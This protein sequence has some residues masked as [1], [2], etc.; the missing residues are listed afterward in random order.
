VYRTY[1]HDP[2]REAHDRCARTDTQVPL[3]WVMPVLVTVEAPRTA[4]VSAMPRVTS[5]K[6]GAANVST[7]NESNIKL[8]MFPPQAREPTF[9][10]PIS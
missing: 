10:A 5:P 1:L 4:K 3:I 8:F 2:G 9:R 7:V 6:A